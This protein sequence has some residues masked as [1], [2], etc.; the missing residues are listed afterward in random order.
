MIVLSALSLKWRLTNEAALHRNLAAI[1]VCSPA[2]CRTSF[3]L[4]SGT[5]IRAYTTLSV[6]IALKV[7]SFL[8]SM[9]FTQALRAHLP[10]GEQF[11]LTTS[12]MA[13]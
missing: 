2:L 13:S 8:A 9:C 7:V 1:G 12:I 3:F 4:Y 10:L 6:E 5:K 11:F